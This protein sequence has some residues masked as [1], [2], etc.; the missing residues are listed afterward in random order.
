MHLKINSL[1][2]KSL[3]IILISIITFISNSG[4]LLMSKF[5]FKDGNEG[6]SSLEIFDLICGGMILLSIVGLIYGISLRKKK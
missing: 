2:D 3:A 1:K 6:D 5:A 4:G